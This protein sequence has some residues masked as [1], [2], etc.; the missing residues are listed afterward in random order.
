MNTEDLKNDVNVIWYEQLAMIAKDIPLK[1]QPASSADV[2]RVLLRLVEAFRKA[3]V[4]I[5]DH[6]EELEKK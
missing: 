4:E 5:I 1:D 2:N 6:M 3:T